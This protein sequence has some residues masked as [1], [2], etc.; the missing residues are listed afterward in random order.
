MKSKTLRYMVT[1]LVFLAAPIVFSLT[2]QAQTFELIHTFTG[3]PDGAYPVAGLV[4]GESGEFYGTTAG[5]GLNDAGTVFRLERKKP[6][7]ESVLYSFTGGD[8]GESPFASLVRD[9]LGNLYATASGGGEF[10]CGTVFKLDQTGKETVLYSFGGG[11]DGAFPYAGVV[12]DGRGNV[13][14]VAQSGGS[15]ASYGTIFKVDTT[16]NETVLYTFTG[17]AAGEYPFAGLVWRD[18]WL[19]GTTAGD[20]TL[21]YG[22]VFKV[23]R[24]GRYTLLHTFTG[25]PDG[26]FPIAVLVRDGMGNLY[27]TTQE[28]GISNSGTIFKVDASGELTVIY[29]FAGAPDGKWPYSGLVRDAA[30][31]FYGTT[32][33]GGSFDSGMIFK[34]DTA[35]NLTTLYSFTG[36]EDG[37]SPRGTLL[38]DVAGSLY[39]TASNGGAYG[40]GTLFK[41]TPE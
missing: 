13:Y 28:G 40:F 37:A 18:G 35:G 30:G 2:G 16:G 33:L 5:G 22:T 3:V 1:M 14:G 20:G 17:G 15:G 21:I 6:W 7:N 31:N 19:Y 29:N 34:L 32:A 36:G 4:R 11:L 24:T 27:G 25:Q 38:R 12:L 41:L 9:R 26:A 23:A 39:G 8:D 10:G